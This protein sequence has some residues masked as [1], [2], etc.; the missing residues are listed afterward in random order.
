MRFIRGFGF[1][2]SLVGSDDIFQIL[3]NVGVG[4]GVVALGRR[5]VRVDEEVLEVPNDIAGARRSVRNNLKVSAALGSER[6]LLLFLWGRIALGQRFAEEGENGVAILPVGVALLHHRKMRLE[7]V[8]GTNVRRGIHNLLPL[9]PFLKAE[10][11]SWK[12]KNFKLVP[13][14]LFQVVHK[15][16]SR[17][18]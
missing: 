6:A 2:P 18:S 17:R 7:A 13:V 3:R 15:C 1:W 9:E 8:A 4:C 5:S 16:V 14:S 10:L 11:V 12:A